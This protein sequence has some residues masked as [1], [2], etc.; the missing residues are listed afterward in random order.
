MQG[1]QHFPNEDH[2]SPPSSTGRR[3]FAPGNRIEFCDFNWS[4]DYTNVGVEPKIGGFHPQNGWFFSWKSLWTNGWFGG[5]THYFRKHP[6]LPESWSCYSNMQLRWSSLLFDILQVNFHWTILRKKS[7]SSIYIYIY[8]YYILHIYILHIYIFPNSQ[9][10]KKTLCHVS[11]PNGIPSTFN[12]KSHVFGRKRSGHTFNEQEILIRWVYKLPYYWDLYMGV[13]VNSGTPK[14][15]ICSW[16]FPLFSPSIL[17]YPY[18]WKHPY[19]QHLPNGD[20]SF[21][22]YYE[23]ASCPTQRCW[24]AIQCGGQLASLMEIYTSWS[25]SIGSIVQSRPPI[26]LGKWNNMSPT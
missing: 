15:S 8:T 17:G 21:R 16:G 12:Q 25:G 3:P 5:K 6:C 19:T 22:P 4:S 1:Y 18:F 13:S 9:I 2:R 24:Q 14:S 10:S 26:S 11:V 23:M 7:G 20:L